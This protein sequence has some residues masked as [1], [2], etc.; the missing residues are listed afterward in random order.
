M[1]RQIDAMKQD[2]RQTIKSSVLD[3]EIASRLRMML[4]AYRTTKKAKDPKNEWRL[5][6]SQ[7]MNNKENL[8]EAACA[9][10]EIAYP[11]L[12]AIIMKEHPNLSET[13]AK[14]CLLSFSDLTNAEIAELLELRL[15]TVNQ[16]RSTLRKKLNLKPD[17]MKEQLRNALAEK[18]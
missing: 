11:N 1:K 10:I 4:T 16:N 9:T 2:L 3:E 12:Y 14:V 5:L 13:E 18:A 6:V 17:K 8:F 15:N 7:V